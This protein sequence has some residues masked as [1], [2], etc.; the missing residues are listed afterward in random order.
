MREDL[1]QSVQQWRSHRL[2]SDA[3]RSGA[4][5]EPDAPSEEDDAVAQNVRL[6]EASEP[7]PD[8]FMHNCIRLPRGH[9]VA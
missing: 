8:G 6:A 5:E 7:N 1:D 2:R 9:V 4:K 3:Q